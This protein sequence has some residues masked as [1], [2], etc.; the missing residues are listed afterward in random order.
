[1]SKHSFKVNET[2]YSFRKGATIHLIQKDLP[3]SV[4]RFSRGDLVTDADGTRSKHESKAKS[5]PKLSF[6]ASTVGKDVVFDVV[7]YGDAI[8][9]LLAL[10]FEKTD[11]DWI[12]CAAYSSEGKRW[13]PLNQ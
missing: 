13:I 6:K 2:F 5:F 1:M 12:T 7:I 9:K 4:I 11:K 10:E 8:P 3:L